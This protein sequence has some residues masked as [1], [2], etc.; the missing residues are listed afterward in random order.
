[1]FLVAMAGPRAK[2]EEGSGAE[3]GSGLFFFFLFFDLGFVGRLFAAV[4][5]GAGAS[6]EWNGRG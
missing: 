6:L 5:A 4:R 2:S 3:S 1:M